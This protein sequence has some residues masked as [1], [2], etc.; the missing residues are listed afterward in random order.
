MRSLKTSHKYLISLLTVLVTV[1]VGQGL[2]SSGQTSQELKMTVRF[3]TGAGNQSKTARF[4]VDLQNVG[5][6]DLVLNLGF[7][8]AN[9][10]RQYPDA[11]ILTIIDPQ[12]NAGQFD[13]IGPGGIAG[14]LDPLIVPLPTGSTFSLPVDLDKYWAAA[15]KDFDYKFQRGTY[16]LEARFSGKTVSSQ[17]ANLDVKG[18]ALMPYWT[19]T[20]TSNQL[21]FEINK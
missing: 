19:G 20:V 5:D 11:I 4:K 18:I 21:Q 17:E 2:Q 10:R 8:L 15:P 14:R 1:V 9:G 16:S 3:D 6:H 13:L 7:M 12:G